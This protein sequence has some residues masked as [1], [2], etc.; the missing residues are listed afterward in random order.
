MDPVLVGRPQFR[1]RLARGLAELRAQRAARHS[2]RP[3]NGR[4]RLHPSDYLLHGFWLWKTSVASP[5]PVILTEAAALLARYMDAEDYDLSGEIAARLAVQRARHGVPAAAFAFRVLA[6]VEDQAGVLPCGNINL[7]RLAK[8]EGEAR[9]RYALATAY[10]TAYVMGF[11]CAA[12]LRP[13]R[14]PP[15]R[16]VGPSVRKAVSR[17]PPGSCR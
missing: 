3:P 16:I 8:L 4:L 9:A 2:R 10:H 17:P 12:S 6:S 13:G 15:V 5:P 7:A 14:A 1:G 11:L